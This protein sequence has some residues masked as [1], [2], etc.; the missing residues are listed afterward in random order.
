MD[1]NNNPANPVIGIRSFGD[2]PDQVAAQGTAFIRGL[3]GAGALCTLKHFPGHGDTDT[4]SH[5]GLPCVE[6]PMKN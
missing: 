6:K 1:V 2:R 4:D 5:T 3:H